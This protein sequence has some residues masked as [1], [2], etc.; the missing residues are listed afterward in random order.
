MNELSHHISAGQNA[1]WKDIYNQTQELVA[2]ILPDE[3]IVPFHLFVSAQVSPIVLSVPHGGWQYPQSLV[4]ANNFQRCVSLADAGTA[5][6][7]VM[8]ASGNFPYW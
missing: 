7:G 6:L 4:T 5:E 2:Q 1:R 3:R 8:L